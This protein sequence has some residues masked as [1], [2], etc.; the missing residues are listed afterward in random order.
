[1]A[2]VDDFLLSEIMD[3]IEEAIHVIDKTGK[4][5]FYNRAAAEMDGLDP[6]E[7]I[8]RHILTV[9]PSL[10]RDTSTL[11]RAV[12]TGVP[13]LN[14]QQTYITQRGASITTVNSTFPL[15]KKGE[16]VGA[17][18]V[19]KDITKIKAL[20]DAISDLRAEL[21]GRRKGSPEVV[22]ARAT[23]TLDDIIG[24]SP[25]ILSLKEIAKKAA[26]TSSPVLIW[27]ETG[28]GKELFVQAIHNASRR[29]AGPFVAQNCS[30]LPETLLEG[31]FFGTVRGSFTGSADR[32]GLFE[33]AHGG[34]LYLDELNSMPL[35]LQAKLLRVLESGQVR[36][37]G[38]TKLRSVDVRIIAS[39]SSDPAECVEAGALRADMYYRLNVVS[40]RIPP[41]RERRED[42]PLLVRHFIALRNAAL[43]SSVEG[44]SAEVM[45]I[46]QR[47]SWPGNVRELK[48][49]IEAAMNLLPGRFIETAHLSAFLV[50]AMKNLAST[51]AP[52]VKQRLA[53]KPLKQ[54]IAEAEKEC[55]IQ[56][57]KACRG[58]V[59]RAAKLLR[60]P[61]STLQYRIGKLGIMDLTDTKP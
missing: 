12:S 47:Y 61:R 16:V 48:H 2:G 6:E 1:M 58:N 34:T 50:R 7:V 55:I 25:E 59:A 60:V 14:R 19:S 49:T 22:E 40:F 3:C 33:L 8:G 38:D 21:H 10:T 31:I 27:G 57:L 11:L 18:E 13:I 39:T 52:S 28:T 46:F 41:L 44:V 54:Q 35:G 23:F 53:G 45:D 56:A 32:P 43:N 29:R 15:F 42:I 9:Y 51:Q 37:L 36:R 24:E 30:A 4:T 20:V 17:V 26:N 5:V